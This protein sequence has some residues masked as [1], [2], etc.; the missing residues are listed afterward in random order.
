MKTRTR[1]ATVVAL[2]VLA[3]MSSATQSLAETRLRARRNKVVNGIEAELRGDYRENNNSP[4]R[5]NA[6]LEQINIPVGTPVAFCLLQNGVNTLVGVGKI[7]LVGGVRVASVDLT[8]SD[9]DIVPQVNP[10]DVLQAR[11]RAVA[12]F[13]PKPGCGTALLVFAPFQQ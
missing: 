13:N 4:I 9:G 3:I 7:A 1:F 6:D 5:L 8:A 11:Q 10:G 2:L 12:P